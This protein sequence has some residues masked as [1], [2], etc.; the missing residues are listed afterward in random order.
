MIAPVGCS[1]GTRNCMRLAREAG[2]RV[3]SLDGWVAA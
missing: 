1:F 3:D 2:I